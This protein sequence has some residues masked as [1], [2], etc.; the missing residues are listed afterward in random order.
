MSYSQ[1]FR[2]FL[3]CAL[4]VVLAPGLGAQEKSQDQQEQKP[5]REGLPK[6]ELSKK[7]RERREKRLRKEL[8]QHYKKWLQEDVAY[9]IVGEE[10]EAFKHLNTEETAKQLRVAHTPP[11]ERN[12]LLLGIRAKLQKSLGE[13]PS[14]PRSDLA[15][16]YNARRLS[17]HDL[18][19]LAG[20]L[21]PVP[22]TSLLAGP[23]RA[24]NG[25]PDFF[26]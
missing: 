25:R 13:K 20:G 4:A 2:C 5:L 9:I 23:P 19:K 22:G 26:I 12:G 1:L 10:R 8:E 16:H 18:P 17:R 6:R 3:G 11:P 14:P 15:S 21:P 24:G 7:Q